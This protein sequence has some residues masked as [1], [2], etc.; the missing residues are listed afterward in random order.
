MSI[1]NRHIVFT[2]MFSQKFLLTKQDSVVFNMKRKSITDGIN[3]INYIVNNKKNFKVQIDFGCHMGAVSVAMW[4]TASS[5]GIVYSIDADPYNATKCKINLK[6]NGYNDRYVFYAAIASYSGKAQLRIYDGKNGW[7][8]LL[9]NSNYNR[10]H[11]NHFISVPAVTFADFI[12]S[13]NISQIDFVKIDI[14]GMEYELLTQMHDLLCLKTI[15][16]VIFELNEITIEPTGKTR[17]ELLVLWE[18]Y[19][20]TLYII[21]GNG[22]ISELLSGVI[23]DAP[24]CDI[25]AKAN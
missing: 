12:S 16:E 11:K 23:P 14:E 17:S 8:T 1:T 13:N 7:Q 25:L 6:L 5:N 10:T 19:D 3:V 2:D 22:D 20:Y 21:E 24:V 15:K 4:T 18:Q 9:G